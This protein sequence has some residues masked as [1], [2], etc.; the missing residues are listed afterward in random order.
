MNA[1]DKIAPYPKTA[2]EATAEA[3]ARHLTAFAQLH[4][5]VAMDHPDRDKSRESINSFTSYYAIA[6]L[7][8]EQPAAEGD[9]VAR[10]LWEAWESGMVVGADLWE[11]LGEYEIDPADI[12]EIA[13]KLI[14]A[15]AEAQSGGAA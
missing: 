6:Y 8:R 7:L 9:R 12:N 3:M 14:A 1:L 15:P 5:R 11:W 13:A 4:W 10:E 2:E